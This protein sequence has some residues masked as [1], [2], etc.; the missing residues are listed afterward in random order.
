LTRHLSAN[1]AFRPCAV[2]GVEW[3]GR[4]AGLNGNA[5]VDRSSV[6]ATAC[7]WSSLLGL[8]CFRDEHAKQRKD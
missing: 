7:G 2:D 1:A 5:G 6:S 8:A 3:F 4:A